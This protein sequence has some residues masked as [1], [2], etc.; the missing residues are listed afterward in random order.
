MQVC[1]GESQLTVVYAM[2][3][4][5]ISLGVED[6]L[7][8]SI[9]VSDVACRSDGI[10]RAMSCCVAVQNNTLQNHSV[11]V[12]HTSATP[13]VSRNKVLDVCSKGT[14]CVFLTNLY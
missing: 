13:R 9:D 8:V 7:S 4:C 14:S 5:R 10:F 12:C 6:Q 11:S 2:L 1:L 3:E